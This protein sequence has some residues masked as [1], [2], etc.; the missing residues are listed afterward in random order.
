MHNDLISS[1]CVPSH[2]AAQSCR[3]SLLVLTIMGNP[4]IYIRPII[5][6]SFSSSLFSTFW[7]ITY[8]WDSTYMLVLW[9][10]LVILSVSNEFPDV[11]KVQFSEFL[12]YS[13]YGSFAEYVI[14]KSV[15]RLVFKL[16]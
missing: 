16:C 11:F 14:C 7:D 3:D 12:L 2:G 4:V 13:S 1:E 15:P 5:H 9:K 10:C 8:I 6:T